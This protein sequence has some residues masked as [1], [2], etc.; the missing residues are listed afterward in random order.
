MEWLN[1]LYAAPREWDEIA[2]TSVFIKE[3]LDR[4]VNNLID[5]SKE[6]HNLRNKI[7]HAVLDSGEPVI[8]IDNGLDIQEVEKWLPITRFLARFLLKDA[9]P[10]IS[11]TS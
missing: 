9:F 8:S 6:L 1:S 4:R 11:K 5:K 7:A 2:L 3:V 10:E